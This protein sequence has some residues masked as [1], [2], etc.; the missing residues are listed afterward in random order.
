M[1][2]TEIPNHIARILIRVPKEMA[3]DDS[4]MQRIRFII[5]RSMKKGSE[6]TCFQENVINLFDVNIKKFFHGK[7]I[8]N[9]KII[10]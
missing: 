1:S 2:G 5:K 8:I 7:N 4:S 3:A 10:P 6:I 9:C